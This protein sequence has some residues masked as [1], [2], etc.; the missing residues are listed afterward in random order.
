MVMLEIQTLR[1][2]KK[3]LRVNNECSND[4]VCQ[5]FRGKAEPPFPPV[6]A[7]AGKGHAIL[8]NWAA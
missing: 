4:T 1:Q 2:E 3:K 7:S 6:A 5:A 8:P